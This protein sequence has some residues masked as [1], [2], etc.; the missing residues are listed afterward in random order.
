M[1]LI[2]AL[3][4]CAV[5]S[6]FAIQTARAGVL[7]VDVTGY[8]SGTFN[9]TAFSGEYFDLHLIGPDSGSG[10]VIDLTSASITIGHNPPTATFTN[11]MQIGLNLGTGAVF[12]RQTGGPDLLDLFFSSSDFAALQHTNGPFG[13]FSAITATSTSDFHGIPDSFVDSN[14]VP[15][16]GDVSFSNTFVDVTLAGNDVA[17]AVPEPSTWAMMLL[18]FAGIGFM[19]YR[20]KSKP[21]FRFA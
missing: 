20:R 14:N 15:Q 10:Q 4:G 5:V 3:F 2:S 18:G 11:P 16:T 19:A 9:G 6:M 21:T 1:K 17:S 7:T 13:P 8:G 12:F